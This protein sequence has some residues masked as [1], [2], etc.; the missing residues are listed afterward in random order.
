MAPGA[1]QAGQNENGGNTVI[2]DPEC[3]GGPRK[4]EREQRPRRPSPVDRTYIRMYTLG[5]ARSYSVAQARSHLP[6]ILDQVES[7]K[8]VELTRRG[9]KVAVVVSARRYEELGSDRS[10]FGKAYR[11]FLDRHSL[12][13]VGVEADVFG[14]HRDR[15]PGRPVRL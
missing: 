2:D 4:P 14:V 1:D 5:M 7:G 15:T 9:R 13:E 10:S 6:E 3:A 8:E 11:S 12:D